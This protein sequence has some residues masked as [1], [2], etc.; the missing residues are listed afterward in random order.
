M[1]QILFTRIMV[2]L[3]LAATLTAQAT[4]TV[5]APFTGTP[6]AAGRK[7]WFTAEVKVTG[8]ATYPLTI[9]FTGQSIHSPAFSFS[10]PDAVL[11]LDPAVTTASTVFNGTNWVTYA[12]PSESGFYF[13]SGYNYS[14]TSAIPGSLSPVSWTGSFSAS[15]L[16]VSV[17]W[18]MA[19]AVYT[20]LSTDLNAVGVK[21]SDCHSCSS[22]PNSHSAGSPENYLAYVI[23]GARGGGGSN[24]TGGESGGDHETPDAVNSA[25]T[26]CA[27]GTATVSVPASTSSCT[28]SNTSVATVSGGMVT[29][30]AA[31]TARISYR[32]TGCPVWQITTVTVA[33]APS[34]TASGPFG[35]LCTGSTVYLHASGSGSGS[36]GSCGSSSS[37][38]YAWTGPGGFTSSAQNPVRSGISTSMSGVYSVTYTD[39][40][41]CSN[42]ATT[43]VLVNQLPTS[44]T[45]TI[46]PVPAC[47]GN[48]VNL[49]G[50]VTGGSGYT[51][52]WTGGT[53]TIVNA[54]TAHA[55]IAAATLTDA[56]TYTLTA[57]ALGCTGNVRGTAVLPAIGRLPVTLTASVNPGTVCEGGSAA[58]MATSAG[59]AGTTTYAWSKP[60]G[61]NSIVNLNSLTAA[62]IPLTNLANAGIYTLT[63][64]VGGCGSRSVYTNTLAVNKLPS[65]SATVGPVNVCVGGTFSLTGTAAGGSGYSLLWTGGT[66]AIANN[67]MLNA[68]VASA[69]AGSAGGYTLTATAPACGATSV[70]TNATPVVVGTTVASS[71]PT[72]NGPV[73]E[74]GGVT[75][76]ANSTGATTWAWTGPGGFTSSLQNPTVTPAVAGVYS[77]TVGGSSAA[78]SSTTVYTTMVTV[79]AGPS[80]TGATNSGPVC[81]GNSATLYAN[82]TGATAWSWTGPGGFVSTL[83]NPVLSPTGSGTYS[84]TI[85]N[86][87]SGCT[88]SSSYTTSLVVNPLPYSAGATNSGPACAG[89]SITLFSNSSN[90]TNW[91]WSGPAGFSS[92]QQNPVV[93]AVSS[94]GTYSVMLSN[95]TTGCV[96]TTVYTTPVSIE[97]LPAISAGS[98]VT[99]CAGSS[100]VLTATG[101]TSYS[102]SP[103][104]VLSSYAG[105]TVTA[106]PLVATTYT[107]SGSSRG[108]S[109]TA[110]VHVSVTALPTIATSAGS[111]ICAGASGT[112]T[113]S[114]ADTYSWLPATGLSSTMGA[115]VSAAPAATTVYTVTGMYGGCT[116]S[117]TVAITVNPLPDAG[118]IAGPTSVCV[119]SSVTMSNCLTGVWSSSD[120]S[121]A[122]IS[123]SGVVNGISAGTATISYTVTNICGTSTATKVVTVN[124][125]PASLAGP[126]S[127]DVGS[128]VLF[129]LAGGTWSSSDPGIATVDATGTI[130]GVSSGTA[131][132]SYTLSNACFSFT[133]T[134]P[135][136]VNT[137][138]LSPITGTLVLCVGNTSTLSDATAGG[139]WSSGNAAVATVSGT[140]IVTGVSPGTAT[141]S[142]TLA[143]SMVYVVVT[144]SALPSAITGSMVPCM[145]QSTALSEADAGGSWSISPSTVASIDA[146]GVVSALTAGTAGVTYTLPSGCF[147]T[148]VLTVNAAPGI[149]A[150]T[151]NVCAGSTA[152]LTASV[153]GGTWSSGNTSVATVS[154]SGTVTGISAGTAGISYTIASGCSSVV[155]MTVTPVPTITGSLL[156]C[157]GATSALSSDATGGTWASSNAAV[158]TVASTGLITGVAGGTARISYI[159]DAGCS[160]SAVVTVSAIQP[161]SGSNIVC[162]GTSATLTDAT[163]GGTWSSS[164]TGVATIGSTT[165]LVT[166][167]SEGSATITYRLSNGCTRTTVVSVTVL[168]PITGTLQACVGLT[169]TLANATSGGTWS[170]SST[171]IASIG[172]TTG[173]ATGLA[174]GTTNITYSVG[175][176]RA[177]A[178][179]TIVA[180][181]ALI[182]GPSVVC[183][184]S[185]I[186]LSDAMTGGTWST[187]AGNIS[188]SGTATTSLSVTGI[189][190]GVATVSYT[191]GSAGC[192]RTYNV[193]VGAPPAAIAGTFTVCPGGVTTLSNSTTGGT[194]SSSNTA[195]ATI[196]PAL[197]HVT[198]MTSG[199]VNITYT[200][201]T[202]CYVTTEMTVVASPSAIEGPSTVCT[203][204]S[205]TLSDPDGTGTW[206][207]SNVGIATVGGTTGVV[208]GVV[209]GAPNI[210]FT[211]AAT[212]CRVKKTVT[213][214]AIPNAGTL[215]GPTA[216]AVGGTITLASTGTAG[217]SWSSSGAEATVGTSGIVTGVSAGS[218]TI[219]YAVINACGYSG[220]YKPITIAAARGVASGGGDTRTPSMTG[221]EQIASTAAMQTSATTMV[222]GDRINRMSTSTSVV[223]RTS[224]REESPMAV[225][226]VRTHVAGELSIVPNPSKG[227]LTVQGTLGT[228]MQGE[229]VV[230]EVR[231]IAGQ[232]VYRNVVSPKNGAINEHIQLG[233]A[234]AN[235]MYTLSVKGNKVQKVSHFVLER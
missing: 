122:A 69:A 64:T 109:N 206:T 232:L 144:V 184:G 91:S 34:L 167:I 92:T 126:A 229:I 200:T 204:S 90:A 205:I 53:S 192:Y 89:S 228:N 194:W 63:A 176:C 97:A 219:T 8:T 49:N 65:L 127:V 171:V 94:S 111:A 85:S 60:A 169:T 156:V 18:H 233:S 88:A 39:G 125:I 226:P 124:A 25:I 227:D 172:G 86:P 140:G 214:T 16:G 152:L 51:L 178:V 211:L 61:G 103:A 41:G 174:T 150:S 19:A 117:A 37:S 181:P 191:A 45:A 48:T 10:V 14:V 153:S 139:S 189:S 180:S 71:G 44:V 179:L 32:I 145:G 198:G 33:P 7:I 158:A 190:A 80:S 222:V 128:D 220:A 42:T 73:C 11:V 234:P 79:G 223:E 77:L 101:G 2:L 78:C 133:V 154:T 160:T 123:S 235:G 119:G 208:T 132:I 40:H 100:T 83:Q 4:S 54:S 17:L 20:S 13:L 84:L 26:I 27:G 107:V 22:Y 66:G 31:G 193:T 50:T 141:I 175:S 15:R 202:G 130:S 143:S 30:V 99:I 59:G 9:Y 1:R 35:P 207:S 46:S 98:D 159:L 173:I 5:S 185:T 24:Y 188:I 217:G 105:A 168:T 72:N 186:I 104:T 195:V 136:S 116:N 102:W 67:T 21:P 108:C 203:G 213:V 218:V 225:I 201:S 121:V 82:S 6:I 216:V 3:L 112:L 170:S 129:S 47:F 36:G 76:F 38:G 230:V 87:G 149:T 146:S 166:G 74:G 147:T 114:G 161:I 43:N 210:T 28:S 106:N 142:Y 96:Q 199:T 162:V 70:N 164:N 115:S 23:A 221:D 62:S 58:L 75:L 57:V 81:V 55:N 209:A 157:Q 151:F 68:Y 215:T 56:G 148:S 155:E 231:N 165:G 113:A 163:T 177:T 212:G 12:R 29:G 134:K 183:A 95:A 52:L 131:T 187:T 196:A 93:S 110:T 224:Y 138:P 118:T 197:G 120:P 135:I 137:V 182:T